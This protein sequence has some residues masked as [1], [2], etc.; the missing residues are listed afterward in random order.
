MFIAE[1]DVRRD[2]FDARLPLVR[3]PIDAD[4]I[5][6]AFEESLA[7]SGA[8]GAG[9]TRNEDLHAKVIVPGKA[10]MGKGLAISF[11]A[12]TL[13]SVSRVFRTGFICALCT[14]ITVIAGVPMLLRVPFMMS[15]LDFQVRAAAPKAVAALQRQG[16]WVLDADLQRVTKNA[17]SVC[18]LWSY[19]YSARGRRDPA[20]SITTCIHAS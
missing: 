7:E 18:F 5:L 12:A 1:I 16:V 17:D 11:L 8:D 2:R 10:T 19:R 14:L 9:G 3:F 4:D 13:F 20:Q 15:F 6:S